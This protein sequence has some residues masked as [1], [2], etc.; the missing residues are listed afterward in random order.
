MTA[1]KAQRRTPNLAISEPRVGASN[2][3]NM[4][5]IRT[6]EVMIARDQ[7][8]SA[9]RGAMTSPVTVGTAVMNT[10]PAKP[11]KTVGQPRLHSFDSFFT[12]WFLSVAPA[13]RT[14][15]NYVLAFPAAITRL[16]VN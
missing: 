8:N 11:L 1:V 2:I 10:T 5:Q 6:F 3:E 7:P 12:S 13:N 16:E 4:E 9:I 15:L 14:G